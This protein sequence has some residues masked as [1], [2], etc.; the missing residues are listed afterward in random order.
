VAIPE[1]QLE[2]WSH[3]GAVA[4]SKL[5]HESIR[6]ALARHT[7]PDRVKYEVYLQG[8]YRNDT[9]IR[10]DSDVDVVAE[11]QSTFIPD[12]SHLSA[13]ELAAYDMWNKKADYSW[14]EFRADTLAALRE[15]YGSALVTEGPRALKVKGASGRLDADVIVCLTHK[16]FRRYA[17]LF[18]EEHVLGITF[19]IPAEERW[20]VNYPKQHSDNATTKHQATD[21]WFKP[22]VRL[23][24]NI[25]TR[26]VEDGKLGDGIARSYF[27]ECLL[28]NVPNDKFGVT[29]DNT[30]VNVHNWL[31]HA[32]LSTFTCLNGITPLCGAASECW[33][34]DKASQ[35]LGALADLW[36]HWSE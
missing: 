6:T 22:S 32:D 18:D 10:G 35:Y 16:T 31:I 23:F 2:T 25:R 12:K 4:T 3:Q 33:T 9:N 5:T 17:T 36:K 1:G 27:I 8:S 28:G 11:L 34:S 26:L 20:I 29:Y 13:A 15:Y 21:G 14:L 30:V 19:F 24:K 7:W